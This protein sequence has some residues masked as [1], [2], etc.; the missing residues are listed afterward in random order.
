MDLK[1]KYQNKEAFELD[2]HLFSWSDT[3]ATGSSHGV[4]FTDIGTDDHF[5]KG[6]SVEFDESQLRVWD[7]SQQKVVEEYDAEF[8]ISVVEELLLKYKEMSDEGFGEKFNDPPR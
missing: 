2:E 1:S 7:Y 8:L 5:S 4:L 3:S 6:F